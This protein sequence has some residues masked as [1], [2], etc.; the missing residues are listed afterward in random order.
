MNVVEG[1]PEEN[2]FVAHYSVGGHIT[3]VLG[4]NMAKAARVHR[5]NVVEALARL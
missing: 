4:W 2:R 1:A 5:Q 3:G